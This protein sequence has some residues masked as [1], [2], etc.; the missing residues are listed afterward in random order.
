MQWFVQKN[1]PLYERSSSTNIKNAYKTTCYWLKWTLRV[2][3]NSIT[4]I[5][6]QHTYL[7]LMDRSS[8]D[9]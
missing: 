6:S 9:A 8:I 2:N 1:L 3:D 5:H 4:K 7:E